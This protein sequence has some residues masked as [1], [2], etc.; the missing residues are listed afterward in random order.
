M[1]PSFADQ[2]GH[3]DLYL[4][5]T[6]YENNVLDAGSPS[7]IIHTGCEVNKP[8]AGSYSPY[9]DPSYGSFQNAETQLFYL[10]T[11]ALI[12]RAKVY[13]DRPEGLADSLGAYDQP[14]FANIWSGTFESDAADPGLVD[15]SP[16]QAKRAY[17][18]SVIGDWTLRLRY[19]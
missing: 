13:N 17:N 14:R 3:A 8:N 2:G 10:N 11:L 9:T 18:W 16:S 1:V 4:H 6:L 19:D 7:F 12:S 5:R 15:W